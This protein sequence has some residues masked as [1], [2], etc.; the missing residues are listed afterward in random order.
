MRKPVAILA[1]L[2]LV[3]CASKSTEIAPT[4]VSPIQYQSYS[5]NQLAEEAQR[6]ATAAATATG[7]QDHQATSDAVAMGVG[8][9]IFWP[10][11]FFIGGDKTNAAQLAQLKGQ[12]D[13][14]QQ[15]SIQKNCGIQFRQ[16]QQGAPPPQQSAPPPTA[17]SSQK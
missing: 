4:Y 11:L 2:A 14:I 13:A 15:A 1:A 9:V 6:V 12:M 8:L 10:S 5:C 16:A 17:Y 7:V 3:G